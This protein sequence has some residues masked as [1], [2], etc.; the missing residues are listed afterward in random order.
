MHYQLFL[1]TP[2]I[3][4]FTFFFISFF[5]LPI[6]HS[7]DDE[8][9]ERCFSPF[10]CGNIEN[11]TFPFWK[12]DRPQLCRQGGLKLTKCEDRQQP[13]INIG[14]NEFQLIY[15]NYSAYKMS[16]AR[17]D[18]W[19]HI[20]ASN[21]ITV[22]LGNPFLSYSHTNRTLTFYFNCYLYS[23][24]PHLPFQCTQRPNS[25]YADDLDERD[26]HV[27]LSCHSAIQ[28]QVN[29][30]AS[31]EL[32]NEE[33]QL[34]EHWRWGF[35]VVYNL[36]EIFCQK[37]NSLKG[38]CANLTSPPY[39]FCKTPGMHNLLNPTLRQAYMQLIFVHVL[40]LGPSSKIK[41]LPLFITLRKKEPQVN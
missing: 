3:S 5:I 7:Q 25:F 31:A 19:E 21:P 13:V 33:Q 28:V 24:P 12:D 14:G 41:P 38:K 2:S 17:N 4:I 40:I 34:L 18:L 29:Q 11:L 37:C 22:E 26:Q 9:F 39:P 36:P 32:Q 10:K 35:D 1:S 15:F 20:C 27:N 16:I 8:N 23:P 6:S 30:N